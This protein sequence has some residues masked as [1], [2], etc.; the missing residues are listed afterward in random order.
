MLYK[1]E[2]E[3]L[4]KRYIFHIHIPRTAGKYIKNVFVVNKWRARFGNYNI[5]QDNVEVPHLHYPGYTKLYKADVADH[6]TVVRDPFEKF[7]SSLQMMIR[8]QDSD[9]KI[10]E[11]IKDK[12]FLFRFL[13]HNNYH[14][15]RFRKQSD[16]ISPKT[17]V[18]K[19]EDGLGLEFIDWVNDKLDIDL[20]RV[21][22]KYEI[23]H[24]ASKPEGRP[25]K[26]EIDP[27]VE[28]HIREYYREDYENFKY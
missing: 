12:E 1:K 13:S 26:A 9:L 24:P 19:F 15:N 4:G 20:H 16:F 6:F 3:H 18:Y 5:Q 8:V 10:Y 23:F 17:H 2:N 22:Y 27:I 25:N 7:K 28:D 14:L 21:E 11:K